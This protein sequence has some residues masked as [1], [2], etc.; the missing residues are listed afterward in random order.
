MDEMCGNFKQP[1]MHVT[2]VP[3]GGKENIYKE[4][5]V[6]NFQTKHQNLMKSRNPHI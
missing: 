4:L 5:M 2:R 1:D 6:E 3:K